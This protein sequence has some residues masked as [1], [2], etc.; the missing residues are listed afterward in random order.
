MAQSGLV[1]NH[2]EDD[3][4]ATNDYTSIKRQLDVT[5]QTHRAISTLPK[6]GFDYL[7]VIRTTTDLIINSWR[8]GTK[9]QYK[10]YFNKWCLYSQE[11][12]MNPLQPTTT[13]AIEFL[14]HLF[15]QGHSH[16]QIST[17]RSALSSI[18]SLT[19]SSDIS[20]GN[21]PIVKRLMK[22]IYEAKP[23]LPKYSTIWNVGTVFNYFRQIEHQDLM[24][25]SLLGKKLAL[26]MG[27]LSGGQRSQT[28][29]SLNI[30]DIKIRGDKCII[31]IMQ[32]IKQTRTG[33]HMKPLIFKCFLQEPKLCVVST[34][35]SYINQ[36]K[37][38]RKDSGLFISYIAPFRCVT[39]DTICRWCK[40]ILRLAGI[41]IN[42]YTTHSSGAA[43]S[44]FAKT[45]GISINEIMDS[46]GW[47]SEKSFSR[48]YNKLWNRNLIL[49][50]KSLKIMENNNLSK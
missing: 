29:H 8:E 44:S 27:L 9:S 33:K 30:E 50:K 49:G 17:A 43:A 6:D 15:K 16:G 22:G 41:D 46:A 11:R 45:K 24:P 48:H 13:E 2:E 35:K 47:S 23:N 25:V 36:T 42:L 32:K 34:L 3:D 5:K 40:D 39:K 21:L 20:F 37:H 18:I 31:P 12:K 7:S 1:A 28:L 26:L 4:N 14:T 19:N 38:L 10:L